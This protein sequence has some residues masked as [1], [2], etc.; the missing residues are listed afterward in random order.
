MSPVDPDAGLFYKNQRERMFCYSFNTACDRNGFVLGNTVSAG[1]VHDSKNFP[2]VF[3]QVKEKFGAI[4]AVCADAGYL[5]P[6]IAKL[7]IDSDLR[8]VLPYKSPSTKKGFFR[9]HEY[10][11]DEY[12]D[13]YICPAGNL[14]SYA[15]TDRDGRSLYKSNPED[16][17]NCPHLHKCTHS[18]NHQKIVSRHVWA[19]HLET[20]NHLR[21]SSENKRIY[22]KRQQTIERVFADLKEKHGMRYTNYRGLSRVEDEALLVFACMNLKKMATWKANRAS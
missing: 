14:L 2:S 18:K 7:I 19:E 21:H 1:N 8:P 5:A 11:Y 6:H 15:T 10:V 22:P 9:K 16:C 4:K 12:Y 20:C 3:N 13:T 17:R